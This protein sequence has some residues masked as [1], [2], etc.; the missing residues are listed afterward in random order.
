[1][2]NDHLQRQL[3]VMVIRLMLKQ[4]P[5]SQSPRN[6]YYWQFKVQQLKERNIVLQKENAQVCVRVSYV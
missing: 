4:T 5:P 2:A 6:K 3:I 1:M